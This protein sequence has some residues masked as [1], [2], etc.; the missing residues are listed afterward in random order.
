MKIILKTK[1]LQ[2]YIINNSNSLAIYYKF[3]DINFMHH[4]WEAVIHAPILSS[5]LYQIDNLSLRYIFV[6]IM[7]GKAYRY[8]IC[9]QLEI[10]I[11]K[12][13]WA[14]LFLSHFRL[15]SSHPSGGKE[16]WIWQSLNSKEVTAD[17][18]LLSQGIILLFS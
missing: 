4:L 5:I 17:S 7:Y 9:T 10:L 15:I 1:A 11:L 2:M 8:I 16:K 12:F 18:S 3:I 14:K 6:Y 13:T